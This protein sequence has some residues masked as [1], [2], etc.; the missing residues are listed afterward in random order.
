MRLAANLYETRLDAGKKILKMRLDVILYKRY[1]NAIKKHSW[2][3]LG[4]FFMLQLH[5]DAAGTFLVIV[6]R[7]VCT[8]KQIRQISSKCV[9]TLFYLEEYEYKKYCVEDIINSKS[10]SNACESFFQQ[11]D[12]YVSFTWNTHNSAR[13]HRWYVSDSLKFHSTF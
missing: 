11:P 3:R 1:L 2:P 10:R 13:I 7:R 6:S 4:V 9:Q 5:F 12:G 8:P